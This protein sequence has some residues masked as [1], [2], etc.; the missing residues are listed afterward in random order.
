M[1]HGIGVHPDQP[2]RLDVEARLLA[3]LA[4]D[5]AGDRLARLDPA[6][7]KSPAERVVP[8][9]QEDAV[10]V[11]ITAATPGRIIIRALYGSSRISQHG[12]AQT[13]P[14]SP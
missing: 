10:A 11:K 9:L 2:Q 4:D 1:V 12:R 14:T 3:H 6:A 7:R 5:G 8:A 13:S